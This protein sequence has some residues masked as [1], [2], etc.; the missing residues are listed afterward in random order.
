ML[1]KVFYK[2]ELIGFK[3]TKIPKGTVPVTSP[4]E[5]LQMV[6]L[7]HPKGTVLKSHLHTPKKRITYQL[8]ECLIVKKGKI[9]ISLFGQNKKFIKKLYLTQGQAFILFSGG[10]GIKMISDS[11]IFELKNGPFIEDKVLI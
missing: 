9:L 3:I 6:T 4:K 8:Q 10:I 1:N 2:K 11:E 7:S 5:F